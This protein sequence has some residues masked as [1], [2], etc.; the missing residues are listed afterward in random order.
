[1]ANL[2]KWLYNFARRK[3]VNWL[4]LTGET[5]TVGATSVSILM[6]DINGRPILCSGTSVPSGAGYAKG[7]L[8]IKTDATTGVRAVY[9]N[10]GTTASANFALLGVASPWDIDCTAGQILV[11]DST[12]VAKSVAASGDVVINSNGVT[13]LAGSAASNLSSAILGLSTANSVATSETSR[14]NSLATSN[15]TRVS[16][17]ASNTTSETSRVNSVATSEVSRVNSL[18]TSTA[19]KLSVTTSTANSG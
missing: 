14:A 7:G 16:V 17:A 11:G 19:L 3:V 10:I 9:S 12:N 8:F 15:A 2:D 4:K 13:S 5:A 18:V 1:M 6:K